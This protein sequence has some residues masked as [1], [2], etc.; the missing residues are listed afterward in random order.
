MCLYKSSPALIRGYAPGEIYF[1][2][3]WY[4]VNIGDR[5]TAI[6]YSNDHG[7]SLEI[8]Y[9]CD[10]DAGDMQPY[11]LMRDATPGVFYNIQPT[12]FWISSDYCSTWQ[13]CPN[14]IAPFSYYATG[15]EN[16]VI[17]TRP[18]D[19]PKLFKS[20]DYANSFEQIKE[21]SIFGF[22]EI[23]TE[24]D[25]LYYYTLPSIYTDFEIHFSN[26]GGINFYLVNRHDSIICGIVLM[27][28]KPIIYHGANPGE[29]YLVSW[30]PPAIFKIFHSTDYG[31]SFEHRFT[32]SFCDFFYESYGF[33]P[34]VESGEFYYSKKLPWFDGINTKIHIYHSSDTAKTFT[35]YVHVLDS[36]FPVN[37][38]EEKL[39]EH[40]N[41]EIIN[42]PNPFTYKTNIRFN[43]DQPGIYTIELTNLS[44][45]AVLR[46]EEYLTAGQQ[47][48]ELNTNDF[49]SGVYLC[50]VKSEGRL[51]GVRKIVKR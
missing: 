51:I 10:I 1:G 32:S 40:K 22:L 39:I 16:G 38:Y 6:F 44:G 18:Y 14:I 3:Y 17:Y 50:S 21:D 12:D 33:T 4:W 48:I 42:Y 8:V 34:G 9:V 25:E 20:Y 35:E 36:N 46:K 11:S 37:I 49:Q 24:S 26:N 2:S 28:H 23:G 41:I 31:Y 7:Q 45:Q 19:E 43:S 30:F 29:L 5:Y 27:G 47:E 13:I 15:T